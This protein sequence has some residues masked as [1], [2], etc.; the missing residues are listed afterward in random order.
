[1]FIIKYVIKDLM[2]RYSEKCKKQCSIMRQNKTKLR[3]ALK[4]LKNWRLPVLKLCA[5]LTVIMKKIIL[6]EMVRHKHYFHLD[7]F[8]QL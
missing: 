5:L 2:N 6:S 8:R 7:Y 4:V 1:M 3:A